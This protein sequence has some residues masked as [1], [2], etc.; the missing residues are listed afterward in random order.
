MRQ[1]RWGSVSIEH[2]YPFAYTRAEGGSFVDW[3][4]QYVTH[5]RLDRLVKQ[6]RP[7]VQ[8]WGCT[9]HCLVFDNPAV[10]VGRFPRWDCINGW[11]TTFGDVTQVVWEEYK[12]RWRDWLYQELCQRPLKR[13]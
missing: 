2:L 10:G 9:V 12:K 4:G 8:I 13:R 6:Q 7:T 11:T 5:K 1:R 3:T